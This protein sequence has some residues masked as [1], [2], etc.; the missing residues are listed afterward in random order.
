MFPPMIG[1]QARPARIAQFAVFAAILG[2]TLAGAQD[3]AWRAGS[4]ISA[5]M[6]E[7]TNTLTLVAGETPATY[8]MPSV[9]ASLKFSLTPSTAEAAVPLALSAEEGGAQTFTA[10]RIKG[11]TM[12]TRFIDA[13]TMVAEVKATG[14]DGA[15]ISAEV[16][17]LDDETSAP[18]TS[19]SSR[20]VLIIEGKRDAKILQVFSHNA[21]RMKNGTASLIVAPIEPGESLFVSLGTRERTWKEITGT[22]EPERARSPFKSMP[23]REK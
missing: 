2:A 12:T 11:V 23:G 1:T 8:V 6:T 17:H 18:M 14:R 15:L 19:V 3:I 4:T 10:A 5:G 9:N 20:P 22:E 16:R 7:T 21:F 13:E